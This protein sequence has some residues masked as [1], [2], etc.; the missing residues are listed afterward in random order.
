MNDSRANRDWYVTFFEYCL[1]W[2]NWVMGLD[3]DH[4]LLF[5]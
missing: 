3:G 1:M 5:D 2:L 4:L